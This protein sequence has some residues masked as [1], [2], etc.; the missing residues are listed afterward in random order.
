[1]Q[2][3]VDRTLLREQRAARDLPN[4]KQHSV[5]VQ[6]AERDR[7]ENEQVERAGQE[8]RLSIQNSSPIVLRRSMA[9]LS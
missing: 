6:P 1:M 2:R 7:F 9:P 3:R 4:A 8:F 5:A